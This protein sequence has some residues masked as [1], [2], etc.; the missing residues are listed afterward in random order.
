MYNTEKSYLEIGSHDESSIR[1][2]IC[3]DTR[4][5]KN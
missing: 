2:E 3:N 5:G 4:M 1:T